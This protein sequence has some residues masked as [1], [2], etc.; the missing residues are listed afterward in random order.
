MRSNS[1][2]FTRNNRGCHVSVSATYPEMMTG[3]LR[4]RFAPLKH[5]QK[6]LA[7]MAGV[8]PRTCEN[9]LAGTC[10]PQGEHLLTLLAEC[11]GLA[12]LLLA[13]VEERKRRE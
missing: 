9:W 1:E 12:E 6:L 8:S 4:A 2:K 11:D 13:A 10:A 5:G 3:F 7:K